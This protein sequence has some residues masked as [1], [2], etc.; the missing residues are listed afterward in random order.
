M[1][2]FL[3]LAAT[4]ICL[5]LPLAAS[6]AETADAEGKA[7]LAA[8]EQVEAAARRAG[9]AGAGAEKWAEEREALLNEARQLTYDIEAARFAANRQETY[10]RREKEEIETL[11]GR[12]QAAQATRRGLDPLMETLYARLAD[13]VSTGLP[14]ALDERR[15][16][17][18][19]VRRTLDDPEASPGA[20]LG[21]LLEALRVEAG[22]G[23]D[24]EAEDAV[25]TVDGAPMALTLLRVG[26]LALLRLPKSDA[27]VERFDPA[28][29][30][31]VRLRNGSRRDVAKGVEIARKRRMAEL[32]SLPVGTPAQLGTEQEAN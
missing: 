5:A 31:W 19:K 14:F 28:T 21:L 23:L 8:Q 20:K 17:L 16:R 10:I 2:R 29:R 24:V 15:A 3:R 13:A 32:I 25:M 12:L 4:L 1:T 6:A 9:K 7:I 26:R 27:W 30:T 18:G 11:S 22:Y